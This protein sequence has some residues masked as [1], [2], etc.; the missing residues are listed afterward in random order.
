[1]Q[2]NNKIN[3]LKILAIIWIVN[4]ILVAIIAIG[5]VWVPN[6]NATIKPYQNIAADAFDGTVAPI[7][8]IPNWIKPNLQNKQLDF[9]Q[10]P[11]SDLIPLPKYDPNRLMYPDNIVERF[12]YTVLYMGSYT[13]NYKENDG[14]HLG[15]DMRAPIGT[16]V[17]SIANGVVVRTVEADATGNKFVVIRHDNVPVNGRNSTIYSN[18]LHLSEIDVKE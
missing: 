10:I 4:C 15:I 5:T 18:Y 11:T 8:Y 16:P 7:S 14:S 6:M 2:T 9:R 13:L 1:M 12:T 3:L 17:L